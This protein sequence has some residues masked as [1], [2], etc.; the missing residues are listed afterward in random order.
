M[1]KSFIN[2]INS[3]KFFQE[4]DK[5]LVAVS[6]GIDS[7]VLLD[8]MHKSGFD[9]SVA[10]VDH[11]TRNGQSTE[12]A[13]FVESYCNNFNVK[14]HLRTL[15]Y[16]P[17][18]IQNFQSFA[19]EQRYKFF[20]SL[21]YDKILT[22]HHSDDQFES[23]L[24]NLFTG[25]SVN[26][27]KEVDGNRVRP[28]LS[29]HKEE[30][31][32]YASQKKIAFREDSSNLNDSYDRNYLRNTVIPQLLS[33][34]PNIKGRM[35]TLME[36]SQS[37][38]NTLENLA[39]SVIPVSTGEGRYK[40]A[41]ENINIY[42]PAAL[43]HIIKQFDFNRTQASNIF[44]SLESVGAQFTSNTHEAVM[45][46]DSLIIEV[47]KQDELQ[48]LEIN[49]KQL[50]SVIHFGDFQIQ[51][52]IQNYSGE[53]DGEF[54]GPMDT[55]EK[56]EIRSWEDGDSFQPKGMNGHTQSLKKFFTNGKIDKLSKHKI[57]IL[58]INGR[59][60]SVL[61]LR[62]SELFEY[63]ETDKPCLKVTVNR[64]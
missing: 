61:T 21:K 12:D 42:G 20:D 46:R 4:S 17:D 5:L 11:M 40:I 58:V 52:T 50:P 10:H 7:M 29:F 64:I 45:D 63:H 51:I 9:I 60:A 34:F 25:R 36:T 54:F 28:L 56:L 19:H 3:K 59:I 48:T 33:R 32:E 15:D 14:F 43:F 37:D 41:L 53:Y 55:I 8:L 24:W 6:G 49:L 22:A 39:D 16:Q 2:H 13:K 31:E 1:F 57:P 23:L 62:R 47:A 26:G 38:M 44:E 18:E 30:I 27:I 35:K